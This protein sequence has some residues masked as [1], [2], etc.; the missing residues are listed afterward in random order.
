MDPH[1]S[2]SFIKKGEVWRFD[3]RFL[4]KQKAVEIEGTHFKQILN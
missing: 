3:E 1:F 2:V 4:A